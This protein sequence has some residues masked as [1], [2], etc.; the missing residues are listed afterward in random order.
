M[1]WVKDC[2]PKK[3]LLDHKGRFITQ[4]LFYEYRVE[5]INPL[6][7]I[8]EFDFI[9]EG[10]TYPSLKKLY[11][12]LEDTTEY[13]F[14]NTYFY[15]WE[16]WQR[17]QKNKLFAPLVAN[18]REELEMKIRARALKTLIR[19]ASAVDASSTTAAKY[20]LEKGWVSKKELKNLKDELE[21]QNNTIKSSVIS[22]LSRLRLK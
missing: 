7:S 15:N 13:E 12:E 16:H 11:L 17:I 5:G 8:K 18:C 21:E 14:A 1:D 9:L 2:D 4:G 3:H 20:V 22:D 19:V 10:K 6:Y